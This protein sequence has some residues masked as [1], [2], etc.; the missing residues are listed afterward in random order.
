MKTERLKPVQI[1]TLTSA[2]ILGVDVLLVQTKMVSLA[3]RD[4]WIAL[5]LG[6]VLA[7][8]SGSIVYYLAILHPGK[9]IPQILIH[10]LGKFWGRLLIIPGMIFVLFYTALSFRIFSQALK[11]FIFDRTPIYAIV[12]LMT[13]VTAYTVYQGIYVIG[14]VTDIL[15][16]LGIITILILVLLSLIIVEPSNIRPILFEN[17]T[18]VLKAAFLG[19]QHFT[20]ISIIGFIIRCTQEDKGR[21]KWYITAIGIAVVLYVALTIVTI[22]VFSAPGTLSLIY[23]TLTLSKSI[24]FPTTFLERF[25][26]ITAILWI[27]IVFQSIVMFFFISV[28]SFAVF[29]NVEE[30]HQ[31]YLVLGHIPALIIIALSIKLGHRVL[32]LFEL[33]KYI[34]SFYGLFVFPLLLLITLITRKRRQN[35]EAR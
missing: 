9:D 25:E 17:S 26:S 28:R 12:I 5:A 30:K 33:I 1:M 20:G 11:V 3:G 8:I 27:G 14:G 32:E 18:A 6:G 7:A 34:Y 2:A 4:A 10:I 16:P 19:H 13:L 21:F 31:K 15:F 35:N 29:F 24:Q 23:P 22:M